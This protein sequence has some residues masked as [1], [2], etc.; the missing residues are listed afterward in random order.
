VRRRKKIITTCVQYVISLYNTNGLSRLRQV[1]RIKK[2]I[3][4]GVWSL[5][6]PKALHFFIK[7]CAPEKNSHFNLFVFFPLLETSTELCS[8]Q[9]CGANRKETAGIA[10]GSKVKL[11]KSV[12]DYKS[13]NPSIINNISCVKFFQTFQPALFKFVNSLTIR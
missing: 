2:I 8:Q 10:M 13:W 4:S 1:E 12:M 6:T 9:L 5:S 11:S 3:R 7:C